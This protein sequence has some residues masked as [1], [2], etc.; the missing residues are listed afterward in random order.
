M[1]G[2]GRDWQGPTHVQSPTGTCFLPILL[3]RTYPSYLDKMCSPQPTNVS[4][5]VGVKAEY[6]KGKSEKIGQK[7]PEVINLLSGRTRENAG[8]SHVGILWTPS[9]ISFR[10]HDMQ[11]KEILVIFVLQTE[12]GNSRLNFPRAHSQKLE[13]NGNQ[14]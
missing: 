2:G 11:L 1:C 14:I 9:I 6:T 7:R 8:N 12:N 3:T 13:S 4:H 5:W 10:R